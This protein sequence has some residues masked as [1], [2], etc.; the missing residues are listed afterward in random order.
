M[1]IF[2]ILGLLVFVVLVVVLRVVGLRRLFS[3]R[4]FGK[5]HPNGR[6][7]TKHEKR[8]IRRVSGG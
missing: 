4:G 6:R 8:A 2:H 7:Y 3:P 5:R 1:T